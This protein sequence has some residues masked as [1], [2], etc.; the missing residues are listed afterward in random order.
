MKTTKADI[1]RMFAWA[2]DEQLALIAKKTQTEA[3]KAQR[4]AAGLQKQ[5]DQMRKALGRRKQPPPKAV[6]AV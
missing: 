3:D 6:E 1:D 4:H 2:T 5:A